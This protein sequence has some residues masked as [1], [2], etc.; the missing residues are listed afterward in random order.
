MTKH[1]LL[2]YLKHLQDWRDTEEAHVE[3]DRALCDFLRQI[4]FDD[5]VEEYHKIAKWYA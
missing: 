4:G 3:A 2:L 1:E 5:V